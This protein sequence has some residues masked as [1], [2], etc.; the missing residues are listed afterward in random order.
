M[1]HHVSCREVAEA[2]ELIFLILFWYDHYT[3]GTRCQ[4]IEKDLLVDTS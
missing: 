1:V 2:A 4:T 3:G